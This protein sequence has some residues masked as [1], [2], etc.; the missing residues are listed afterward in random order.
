MDWK[1]WFELGWKWWKSYKTAEI[2]FWVSKPS[3][4][5]GIICC[6]NNIYWKTKWNNSCG[7]KEGSSCDETLARRSNINKLVFN[8]CHCMPLLT[9]F[10]EKTNEIKD[11]T[12]TE[13]LWFQ[14]W[15]KYNKTLYMSVIVLSKWGRY[16]DNLYVRREKQSWHANHSIYVIVPSYS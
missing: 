10:A 14:L 13:Q 5:S 16:L 6:I 7:H 9:R 8:I 15:W 11:D 12:W 2:L 3:F 4:V 1:V